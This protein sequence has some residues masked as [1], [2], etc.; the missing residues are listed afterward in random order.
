VNKQKFVD[1]LRSPERLTEGQFDELQ[2]ILTD[3]PYF[4][5]AKS[6]AARGAKDIEHENKNQFIS[7]AAIYATDR[8][9]LKKYINGELVFLVDP[10]KISEDVVEDDI[11]EEVQIKIEATDTVSD[12]TPESTFDSSEP[13][14]IQSSVLDDI[15]THVPTGNEVDQVLDELER[16]IKEL[17]KSRMHFLEVQDN[18]DDAKF[19]SKL[20]SVTEEQT[21]SEEPQAIE[22]PSLNEE[23]KEELA[24]SKPE[25]KEAPKQEEEEESKPEIRK[26]PKQEVEEEDKPVSSKK[27]AKP[28]FTLD[29]EALKREFA[30][31][32]DAT[33]DT[34]P[35]NE[36]TPIIIGNMDDEDDEDDADFF[37]PPP[38]DSP[39]SITNMSPDEEEPDDEAEIIQ[40]L[41]QKS[42]RKPRKA[43]KMK[44]DDFEKILGKKRE[45]DI[46]SDA[47][48]EKTESIEAEAK[49]KLDEEK[50][51]KKEKVEKIEKELIKEVEPVE[52]PKKKRAEKTEESSPKEDVQAKINQEDKS[53]KVKEAMSHMEKASSIS[54][55]QSNRTSKERPKKDMEENFS[56][57]EIIKSIPKKTAK[58]EGNVKK[59][60][61]NDE[62]EEMTGRNSIKSFLELGISKESTSISRASVSK[63]RG[64][65]SKSKP[66]STDSTKSSGS[67]DDDESGR[68]NSLIDKFITEN[69][70]IQRRDMKDE[71]SDLSQESVKWHPELAS[72]YLAQIY[73]D[74]GNKARAISI[75]EALSLK[76]PEK[77][78][79]FAGLIKKLKK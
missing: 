33:E 67:K 64:R 37:P 17:E 55:S 3:Y 74:Q 51:V 21:S 16:D 76:F 66:S 26:V 56:P 61:K 59:E 41:P 78:S 14:V 77:K 5:I 9:H 44:R 36:V 11:V 27:S 22:A 38:T 29:L 15:K 65:A 75:Y 18:I 49:E 31:E 7:S 8:K 34:E 6:I 4:S 45:Q 24:E 12:K 46:I 68:A 53:D 39:N 42:K 30:L 43:T 10:P 50:P 25:I 1:Y 62:T 72:E 60:I 71:I 32:S 57:I 79:Y 48:E 35:V 58:K 47:K 70:S 20:P 23:A 63:K 2:K 69:P 52:T 73:A 13:E 19:T 54:K 28:E 40:K